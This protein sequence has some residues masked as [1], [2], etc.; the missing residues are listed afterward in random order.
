LATGLTLFVASLPLYV[1]WSSRQVLGRWSY[2]YAA[3]L[4]A[5]VATWLIFLVATGRHSSQGRMVTSAS[6]AWRR[7]VD[8]AVC[9]WGLGYF[10]GALDSSHNAAKV[11]DLNLV[12]ST[13]PP[14]ALLEWAAIAA[15]GVAL[16]TLLGRVLPSQ[17]ENSALVVGAVTFLLILGEGAARV[18]AIAYPETQGFPTYSSQL[19][20]R[21]HVKLNSLGYRDAEHERRKAIGVRRLLVVGDSYTYGVGVASVEQ[22]FA[23]QLGQLLNSRV[24]ETWE[25]I[26]AG[27]P[28]THTLQ[29]IAFLEQM[30]AFSPDLILLLYV[31][32]DIDYLSPVTPRPGILEQRGIGQRL[33]PVRLLFLNSYLF[34]EL[35]VRWRKVSFGMTSRKPPRDP[36]GDRELMNTHFVDLDRFVQIA[37]GGG[38]LVKIVAFDN[39]IGTSPRLAVRYRGFVRAAEAHGLPVCS[40]AKAFVNRA[41]DALQVNALDG[42][43][44]ALANRLAAETAFSCLTREHG[45]LS[46]AATK[47]G[48]KQI[49]ED[50][51]EEKG[52]E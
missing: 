41:P 2:P 51:R 48:G 1:S 5:C 18:K 22:R 29:H 47:G 7:L 19:W 12:G 31:F 39:L 3:F 43:P 45:H 23:E 10:L 9:M 30:L 15:V 35:Y 32:N 4:L 52:A 33:N 6:P 11:L 8:I 49:L 37:G 26:S 42:H 40:L 44:N 14:A 28:D 24:G 36:Y 46:I 16:A 13:F 34:Q 27:K 17:W 50:S 25:V 21:K 20:H 38:A